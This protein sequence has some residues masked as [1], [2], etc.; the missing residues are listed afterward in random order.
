[1]L[2]SAAGPLW[3][4][5]PPRI[6]GFSRLTGLLPR[7]F[8]VP[9]LAGERWYV[10][11][12]GGGLWYRLT[13]MSIKCCLRQRAPFG[14]WR[15]HLSPYSGG[16]MG[17]GQWRQF[18]FMA[19]AKRKPYNRASPGGKQ[20]NLTVLVEMHPYS[21]FAGLPPKDET[22]HYILRVAD[23]PSKCVRCAPRRGK[24]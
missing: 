4:L 8:I 22:T 2:P 18:E 10:V 6:K 9:P 20:A 24:F 14:G 12:K 17:A 19:A 1:M 7:G 16:T 21:R 15:H 11:P 13:A 5:A 3:W 23:A